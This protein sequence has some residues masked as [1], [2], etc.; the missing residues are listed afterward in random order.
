MGVI[1]IPPDEAVTPGNRLC[2]F[3]DAFV[4]A[5]R[6]PRIEFM[7]QSFALSVGVALAVAVEDVDVAFAAG[8]LSRR[9]TSP[10]EGP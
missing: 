3:T 9:A 4:F 1:C 2:S 10:P 5:G 8:H 6:R 7:Y